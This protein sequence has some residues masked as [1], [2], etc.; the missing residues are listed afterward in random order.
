M[1]VSDSDTDSEYQPEDTDNILAS[2]GDSETSDEMPMLEKILNKSEKLSTEVPTPVSSS[3]N[4]SENINNVVISSDEISSTVTVQTSNNKNGRCWDK[5]Q[6]CPY[7]KL[8]YPKLARHLEQIHSSE[9]DVAAALAM[10]KKSKERKQKWEELRSKGNFAHNSEVIKAGKGELIPYRRPRKNVSSKEY[11]PCSHCYSLFIKKDLWKH[12]QNCS[13]LAAVKS[14]VVGPVPHSHQ[15]QSLALL[16]VC[17]A[18]T[19]TFKGNIL[20][21][22]QADSISFVA[23]KDALITNFGLKM[24]AKAGEQVH[25]YNY[26]KQKLR[27][28]ARF[29]IQARLES[30]AV[31][32]LESVID[33]TKFKIVVESVKKL[34]GYNIQTGTFDVPSLALKLGHSLKKC[35]LYLETQAL[36]SNDLTLKQKAEGFYQC[37]EVEW[38]SCISSRAQTTLNEAKYNKPKRLPLATD[39]KKLNLHLKDMAQSSSENLTE[40]P[41]EDT[42]KN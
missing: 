32:N 23:R 12:I 2:D 1:S 41:N 20:D 13:V 42:D 35:A 33:P 31:D 38:N 30:K 27:E 16:P 24:Y 21:T 29:L 14:E 40:S 18:A 8:M 17:E 4:S 36:Q 5:K 6:C 19:K 39:I 7:C 22:M 11:L 37:L 15:K 34:A 9:T 25:Q 28:L 26:I 3:Y 10:P